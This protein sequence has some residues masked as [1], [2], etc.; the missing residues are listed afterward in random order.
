MSTSRKE[1]FNFWECY[2]FPN[3]TC[4]ERS[5]CIKPHCKPIST[6]QIKSALGRTSPS[7][8]INSSTH[9][10]HRNGLNHPLTSKGISKGIFPQ[11]HPMSNMISLT[12]KR[13]ACWVMG[14]CISSLSDKEKRLSPMILLRVM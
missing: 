2:H 4:R 12:S 3:P 1:G 13:L 11:S 8:L 10:C 14:S 9:D 7:Q 5:N 6:F